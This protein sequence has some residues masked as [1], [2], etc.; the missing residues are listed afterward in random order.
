MKRF[1]SFVL[2]VALILIPID[3]ALADVL[4]LPKS[5]K[6]I[7]EEAFMRD[8]SLEQV[9]IPYGTEVIEKKA[10]ANSRL[11]SIYIPETVH[12][13]AED[14]FE[15]VD[16]LT[17]YA[18]EDSYAYSFA[19]KYDHV[20]REA[21]NVYQ[22]DRFLEVQQMCEDFEEDETGSVSLEQLS[23]ELLDIGASELSD[24]AWS[25]VEEYNYIQEEM[26]ELVDDY[27][28]DINEVLEQLS[29]VAEGLDTT[30][31][32]YTSDGVSYKVGGISYRVN[33]AGLEG[34]GPDAEVVSVD[35][36]GDGLSLKLRSGGKTY[37][38][39]GDMNGIDI[40]GADSTVKAAS[41]GKQN[42]ISIQVD[43]EF[44]ASGANSEGSWDVFNTI[45]DELGK[46]S[47]PVQEMSAKTK[48][49]LK[50]AEEIV[51]KNLAK[52]EK[53]TNL[54]ASGEVKSPK[55]LEA[56][57]R[58]CSLAQL[59]YD[60]SVQA[61][62]SLRKLS[63]S[64]SALSIPSAIGSI[65]TSFE[66]W[67]ELG[68]IYDHNHP[69]DA[70]RTD[71]KKMALIEQM[72][73]DCRTARTAYFCSALNSALGLIDAISTIVAMASA[74]TGVGGAAVGAVQKAA[75]FIGVSAVRFML[76]SIVAGMIL[77]ET[78]AWKY[79][80]VMEKDR[81]LHGG[82]YGYV[83]DALTGKPIS[84]AAVRFGDMVA[85]TDSKGYY[86]VSVPDDGWDYVLWFTKTGYTP[87]SRSVSVPENTS[88]PLDI[89]LS[90]RVM[91]TGTVVNKYTGEPIK[92]IEVS[93]DS[94]YDVD[95]AVT[96]ADGKYAIYVD[97]G[98]RQI[99][100]YDKNSS[101]DLYNSYEGYSGRM[102]CEI[103]K[104]YV[105][106]ASLTPRPQYKLEVEYDL[107]SPYRVLITNSGIGF[108]YKDES[109][110]KDPAEKIRSD[111]HCDNYSNNQSLSFWLDPDGRAAEAVC[112]ISFQKRRL[113]GPVYEN[114]HCTLE[115]LLKANAVARLF[116]DGKLIATYRMPT[117]TSE[118]V[119]DGYTY[120]AWN[121]FT[122][123]G[124]SIRAAGY[125][126][127][128]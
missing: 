42:I 107:D 36:S 18:P 119:E 67:K 14:A 10:F 24:D 63:A 103:G 115:D 66:K 80:S 112:K 41:A 54:L 29:V 97:A 30:T 62:N 11:E 74:L 78:G 87:V 65:R 51:E 13:I 90:Q 15:G 109:T 121:V 82:V 2:I 23:F 86:R 43:A 117:I 73:N 85:Y 88:T 58:K 37:Y 76:E 56:L 92:G 22:Y 100:F 64:L 122:V 34:L 1:I 31:V 108:D 60:V 114:D 83:T 89:V 93:S 46:L 70:E 47:Y 105:M 9:I 91:V 77:D 101:V 25:A 50:T 3:A 81:T 7:G 21:G 96:G 38:V 69:L 52:K 127:S 57:Q 102:D 26:P 4:K 113:P 104:S 28:D 6:T 98:M 79:N 68:R 32:K 53:L 35:E 55:D 123:S 49:A 20:W 5:V 110:A 61:S 39:E 75:A 48:D 40:S 71:P 8:K 84:R 44:A 126:K 111:Y 12:T 16:G 116:K 99:T 27:T 33:S 72:L 94:S 59:E 118:L 95:E 125:F 128:E 124:N 120:A 19:W 106:D 45:L 17:I